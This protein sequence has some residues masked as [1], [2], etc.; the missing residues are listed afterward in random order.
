[1]IYNL[2]SL[3]IDY[4]YAVEHFVQAGETLA[5]EKLQV[6]PGGKLRQRYIV[7]SFN[8]GVIRKLPAV[9]FNPIQTNDKIGISSNAEFRT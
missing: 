9:D 4:V 8:G 7:E 6:F 5:S 3:N 1:M 2:G